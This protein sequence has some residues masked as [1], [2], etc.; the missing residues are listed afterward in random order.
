[1]ATWHETPSNTAPAWLRAELERL[2]RE[3]AYYERTTL[4][5]CPCGAIW[6]TYKSDSC[7]ECNSRRGKAA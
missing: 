1:M 3:G 4:R 2:E 7:P 6:H 5:R